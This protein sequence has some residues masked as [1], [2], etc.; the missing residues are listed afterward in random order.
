[1]LPAHGFGHRPD[2]GERGAVVLE[3]ALQVPLL[4]F[5]ARSC[6]SG[7][8][9]AIDRRDQS[10][11]GHPAPPWS[12]GII[13]MHPPSNTA[14]PWRTGELLTLAPGF[15]RL[16]PSTASRNKVARL[17]PPSAHATPPGT[18]NRS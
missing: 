1:M 2:L 5:G 18:A 7:A 16:S 6:P 3:L 12:T 15:G 4:L 13:Q 14:S 10:R 8:E 11:Y 17:S 9:F